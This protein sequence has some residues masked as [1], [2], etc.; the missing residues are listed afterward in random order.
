[1]R[2]TIKIDSSKIDIVLDIHRNSVVDFVLNLM[3]NSY[4]QEM[5]LSKNM[6]RAIESSGF[7]PRC[8]GNIIQRSKAILINHEI[9]PEF[10]KFKT[11]MPIPFCR[12]MIMYTELK[13]VNDKTVHDLVLI[14]SDEIIL[15][16]DEYIIKSRSQSL[17][18]F[19][20]EVLKLIDYEYNKINT[21]LNTNIVT[22][23]E[24]ILI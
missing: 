9:F 22:G 23:I 12:T 15:K 5:I 19:D 16:N 7:V 2:K 10:V 3:K 24:C 8:S 6:F 14:G 4:F 17:P 18:T 20:V 21:L 11:Q 13:N 1:M